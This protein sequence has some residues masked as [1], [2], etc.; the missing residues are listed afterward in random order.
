[1]SKTKRAKWPPI[2]IQPNRSG[3]PTYY[4]DL[5]AVKAGRPGFPTLEQA[6][7][8]AEQARIQRD[9]EGNA[10][11]TL[12]MD[13]RLDAFKAHQILAPHGLSIFE[14]AKYYEK[15]VLAFKTAPTVKEIV[16]RY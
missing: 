13:I 6:Q 5:R 7:T 12:P 11:F 3:Q 9:N 4:V 16:D 2:Y 10:A 8:R 14:V 15:H 1:M